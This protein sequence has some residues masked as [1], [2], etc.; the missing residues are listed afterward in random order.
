MIDVALCPSEIRR[1]ENIDLSDTT[2]VVFDVLRATSTM[3]TGLECGVERFFPVETVE[4]ARAHK[5]QDPSLL[6]AGERGGLPLEGFDLGNSP[7]EFKAIRGKSVVL[8]TTNGTVALHRVRRAKRVY[9]GALLNL[10]ALA[11]VLDS[12]D[13][14]SLLL[15]CAGTGEEFAIEDA[16]AAGGL[17]D[18]LSHKSLSDAAVLVKSLYREASSD[19]GAY[20][21]QS[22][23]GRAL[24][25]IGKAQDV[26]ECARLAVSQA[27]GV[28]QEGAVVKL[29]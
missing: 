10:D 29:S 1:F 9:V 18:R 13:S 17:V 25:G 7:A 3:I 26:E 22:R 6:L 14:T 19:L 21:R 8:T 23:N 5:V 24:A 16:I 20:L 27:V 11:Q 15:V 12:E 28:M 4:V 2:A